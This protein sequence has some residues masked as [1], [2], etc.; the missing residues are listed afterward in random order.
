MTTPSTACL[1]RVLGPSR[2]R[3]GWRHTTD[4]CTAGPSLFLPLRPSRPPPP[5]SAPAPVP[6]VSDRASAALKPPQSGQRTEGVSGRRPQA[7]TYGSL[8]TLFRPAQSPGRGNP[9]APDGRRANVPTHQRCGP[10]GTPVR[11]TAPDA[12]R[13]R[14]VDR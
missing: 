8:T 1:D 3:S 5:R 14:P 4:G 2:V 12:L 11:P 13:W 9:R 10:S 6:G 7:G